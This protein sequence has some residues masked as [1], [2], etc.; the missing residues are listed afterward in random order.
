MP[1]SPTSHA[2][3]CP[4]ARQMA[5][6]MAAGTTTAVDA[7]RAC[8][9]RVA[10]CDAPIGAWMVLD[11]AGAIEQARAVDKARGLGDKIGSLA[12]IPVAVKDNIDT[13]DL[14]T[15]Y[16]SVIYDRYRPGAD[17]A[18]VVQL[19]NAGAVVL[20]KTVTTEFAFHRPG[21]TTNPHNPQHTPGGSSQGSAA[22]VASGQV[23]LAFGTQTAGSVIRPAAFCGV[24]GYKPSWGLI[25]RPGVKVLSDWLDTVG[26]FA[27]DV[28]DAAFFVAHLTGRPSLQADGS[29]GPY[30]IAV[31]REPY[32]TIVEPEAVRVLDQAME[33]LEVAGHTVF[34]LPTPAPLQP[35]PRLQRLVMAYELSRS[36]GHERR[37]HEASLSPIL[38]GFIDEGSGI[39]ARTYDAAM[40][41]VRDV[42]RDINGVFG[43]ADVILS[44]PAPGEAPRGL[45]ATGDPAFNRTWTVLQLPCLTVPVGRGPNGL[46]VGVQLAARSGQDALLLAA[47]LATEA[48]VRV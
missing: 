6:A 28:A 33:A 19:R 47:A 39:S 2:P 31:L 5:E 13:A 25:P 7:V 45:E 23:P 34:D 48:A 14:P 4:T 43:A 16:G 12:G 40:A 38:K 37:T 32:P 20:G 42:I 27:R 44:P 29:G 41:S 1:V 21:K 15:G 30:R 22:A 11:E 18:C 10:A 3:L 46:P 24:V 9:D 35:L 36:L 17:A 8:L 26:V